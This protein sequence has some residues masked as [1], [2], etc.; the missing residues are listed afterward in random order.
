MGKYLVL[1]ELDESKIPNKVFS[2]HSRWGPAHCLLALLLPHDAT[3][4]PCAWQGF[5]YNATEISLEG[6][7]PAMGVLTQVRG[8]LKAEQSCGLLGSLPLRPPYMAI[9]SASTLPEPQSTRA[10]ARWGWSS[11]QRTDSAHSPAPS[12]WPR[13]SSTGHGDS[14][15]RAAEGAAPSSHLSGK[16]GRRGRGDSVPAEKVVLN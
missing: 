2:L 5:E 14:S 1:W 11:P 16:Q 3:M 6:C 13:R 9:R 12:T 4:S 7:D 15:E 8:D 10:P